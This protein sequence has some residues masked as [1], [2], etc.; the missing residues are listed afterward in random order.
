M[1]ATT[2]QC[3]DDDGEDDN[4]DKGDRVKL[5]DV[6]I[7][8]MTGGWWGMRYDNGGGQ[9]VATANKRRQWWRR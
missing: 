5:H 2:N 6:T 3:N 4:N 7:S 9:E 1:M 8:H